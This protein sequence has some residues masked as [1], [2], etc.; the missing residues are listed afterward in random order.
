MLIL[1]GALLLYN[2]L[3]ELFGYILLSWDHYKHSITHSRIL[4][5]YTW[6]TTFCRLFIFCYHYFINFLKYSDQFPLFLSNFQK[7]KGASFSDAPCDKSS[8][9]RLYEKSPG[10][11]LRSLSTTLISFL[12]FSSKRVVFILRPTQAHERR[13]NQLQRVLFGGEPRMVRWSDICVL[14][15][16]CFSPASQLCCAG[17]VLKDVDPVS[18][19]VSHQVRKAIKL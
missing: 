5:L 12:H 19:G 15:V 10:E 14:L 13:R 7:R 4:M 6:K 9:P 11:V 2:N 17:I 3:H 8:N 16:Y 1:V 18:T